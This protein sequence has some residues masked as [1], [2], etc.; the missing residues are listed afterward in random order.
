MKY[1]NSAVIAKN[2]LKSFIMKIKKKR[3]VKKK[4]YT[5]TF[6]FMHQKVCQL[7]KHVNKKLL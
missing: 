3:E 4:N 1:K 7:L 2:K 6:T 5:H